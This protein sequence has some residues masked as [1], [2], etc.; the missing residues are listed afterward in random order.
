M[1]GKATEPNPSLDNCD[2]ESPTDPDFLMQAALTAVEGHVLGTQVSQEIKE[3]RCRWRSS[4]TRHRGS[5]SGE[6]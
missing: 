1:L 3:E 5:K 2:K 4:H 6:E